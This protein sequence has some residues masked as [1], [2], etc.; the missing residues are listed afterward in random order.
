MW[1]WRSYGLNVNYI[2]VKVVK[3]KLRVISGMI[4]LSRGSGPKYISEFS[5]QILSMRKLY[6]RH[7]LGDMN[8]L[9]CFYFQSV[10]WR[11]RSYGLN[12]NYILVKVVKKKLRVIS[13]ISIFKLKYFLD[14]IMF[15][16]I[17]CVSPLY[18]IIHL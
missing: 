17:Y 15:K 10:M 13:G 12:V 7:L 11:W 1:R 16:I 6:L 5:F 18:W 3:K 4:K 2:L 14:R 9:K 8:I